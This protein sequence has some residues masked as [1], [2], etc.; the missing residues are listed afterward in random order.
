MVLYPLA[1]SIIVVIAQ[2]AHTRAEIAEDPE[3][4]AKLWMR[5]KTFCYVWAV[6]LISAAFVGHFWYSLPAEF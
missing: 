6:I 4:E 1:A 3:N 5:F 2:L